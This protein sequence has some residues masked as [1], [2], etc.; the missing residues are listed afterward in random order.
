MPQDNCARKTLMLLFDFWI[1]V[2]CLLWS[3][4]G[5]D[6]NYSVEVAIGQLDASK[7]LGARP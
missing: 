4:V 7:K 3:P 5:P 2:Y 1:L 6:K